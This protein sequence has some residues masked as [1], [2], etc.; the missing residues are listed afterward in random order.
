MKTSGISPIFTRQV[1]GV[2]ISATLDT[3]HKRDELLP[4][5]V[6]VIYQ[7]KTWYY[8]T[9]IR[10]TP[11]GYE[12][13]VQAK[14]VRGEFSAIKSQVEK[15]FDKVVNE[16]I[17]L[18][19]QSLFSLEALR[20]ILSKRGTSNNVTLLDYWLSYAQTKKTTQTKN[21]FSSA[22]SSF[23]KSLGCEVRRIEEGGSKS[24]RTTITGRKTSITPKDVT[25]DMIQSWILYM[26]RKGNSLATQSFYLR[27]FRGVLRELHRNRL[28]RSVPKFKIPEGER[29]QHDFLVVADIIK[30]RDYEGPQKEWAD[31]WLILYMCNGSNLRDLATLTYDK[32]YFLDDE[33]SYVREKTRHKK[34]VRVCIPVIPEL[35][36]ML[37]KYGTEPTMGG[38]VFP[39]ILLDAHTEAAITNRVHDFNMAIRAGMIEVCRDLN[40]RPASP[41]TSRNSYITTLTWHMVSDAFIDGMVGHSNGKNILRGYQGM[42]SPRKRK[43]INGKLFIDPES[44]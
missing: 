37:K 8:R 21:Q 20:S 35:A 43:E 9:G 16:V 42:A 19:E 13:V 14:G 44:Y 2:F 33:L 23:Y 1:E 15:V 11:E 27:A 3:R 39:Q 17:T 22:A 12:R 41:S 26:E 38:R 5:S 7:R 10:L 36:A 30:V 31:W 4:V 18:H 34:P 28:I 24:R 25:V 29:R 32:H 6:R 40:I